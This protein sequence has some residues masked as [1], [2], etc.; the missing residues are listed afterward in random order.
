MNKE[1]KEEQLWF[2]GVKK[3]LAK[4][5]SSPYWDSIHISNSYI[6][7]ITL[8][9]NTKKVNELSPLINERLTDQ[10]INTI[11]KEIKEA[12]QNSKGR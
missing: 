8:I 9:M 11:Q 7:I 5:I 6:D 10:I 3:K 1:D 12:K 4:F 2:E